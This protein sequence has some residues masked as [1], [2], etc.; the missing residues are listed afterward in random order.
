MI[1]AKTMDKKYILIVEDERDMVSVL[2]S[3]LS[4]IGYDIIVSY[5]GQEGLALAQR[6]NPDLIILDLM[7]PKLDG[8]KVC[9]ILKFDDKYKSIPIII[10]TARGQDAD[11]QLAEE[12]GA[13]A[14]IPKTLGQD[15][16]VDRIKKLLL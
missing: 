11:R 9:R 8:Y 15:V 2:K 12:C 14:F 10:Y 1:G 6:H 13:D 16:L 5:D 7:L 4:K 3:R